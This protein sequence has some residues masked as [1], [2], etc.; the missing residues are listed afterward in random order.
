MNKVP[1]RKRLRRDYLR[2]RGGKHTKAMLC[3]LSVAPAALIALAFASNAID[4]MRQTN[5][6]SSLSFFFLAVICAYITVGLIQSTRKYH[7]EAL[8]VPNVL[9]V[10]ANTL[11]AEEILVRA[12]EEPPV[13]QSTVLL[14]AAQ[15]GQETP[16]EELLRMSQGE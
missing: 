11:P 2:I 10:T 7:V 3:F 1:D 6:V 9:P 4:A 5:L 13:A 15:R 14:R 8:Q 12:A 16:Q